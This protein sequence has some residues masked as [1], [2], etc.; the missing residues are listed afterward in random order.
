[1]GIMLI[2]LFFS[3]FVLAMGQALVRRK[4]NPYGEVAYDGL[5]GDLR[6]EVRRILPDF[7]Q[8]VS[9]ITK[10]RDEVRVEGNYLGDDVTIEAQFDREGRL[11]ELEMG[12]C[13]QRDRPTPR[14]RKRE[15]K[16][17]ALSIRTICG[18]V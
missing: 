7:Q 15:A 14:V 16:V 8:S 13:R 6:E 9:H 10:N 18:G 17:P 11:I 3:V 1:M 4:L 5:P 2:A 12:D